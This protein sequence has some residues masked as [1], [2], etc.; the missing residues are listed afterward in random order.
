MSDWPEMQ[1]EAL[2]IWNNIAG[3]WDAYMGDG[4]NDFHNEL[5]KP[6][7]T[8]LLQPGPG[9]KILELGCGAGLYTRYLD[10]LG[11]AVVATDGS[12][13][14]L[15]IAQKRNAGNR[16]VFAALDVTLQAHWDAMHAAHPVFDA[17]VCNMMFMDVAQVSIM[18]RNAARILKPGGVWVIS[19]MHPCFGTSDMCFVAEQDDTRQR[20]C[21]K[22]YR[23]THV[24]P[25]K[26]YGI[27]S[28][29]EQHYYFHR[30]LHVVLGSLFACGLVVNGLEEPAF[31]PDA[32][33]FQP[34]SYR[35][36]PEISPAL[37]I[38]AL[39]P[40]AWQEEASAQAQDVDRNESERAGG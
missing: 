26:G 14:F 40:Q 32:Q 36:M 38:R 10:E 25:F 28:Q 18:C 3:F 19:L 34:L 12:S 21:I 39:K 7:V 15:E 30:P 5:I 6:T 35:S 9:M 22:I 16:A 37:V 23:Y 31:V 20:N 11:A 4:G 2:Q 8:E 27:R 13:V 29:P 17:L 33:G 24:E 1:T